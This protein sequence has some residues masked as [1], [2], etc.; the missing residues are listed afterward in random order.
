MKTTKRKYIS[1]EDAHELL[2]KLVA[3]RKKLPKSLGEYNK[4]LDICVKEF[5]FL[6][7]QR[8]RR[9]SGFANYEDL[10]QDGRVALMLALKSYH[11][12]KGDFFYWARQYI[13]TKVSREANRHSTIKIPIKHASKMQPYKVSQI[14]IMVDGSPDPLCSLEK[15][16]I[17]DTV[18][19]AIGKLPE[20]QQ[21]VI[22]MHYEFSGF[23]TQSI[24][25]ICEELNISR[26]NCIKLLNEA[27][28]SLKESLQGF[29]GE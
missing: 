19:N 23:R 18:V 28:D 5:D 22:K 27:R 7:E 17:K 9:Y 16:R 29:N 15:T 11:P 12:E 2:C 1:S 20:Q 24:T 4:L 3:C 21:R 10:K 6:I 14:P 26:G 25:K 8:T 13:K